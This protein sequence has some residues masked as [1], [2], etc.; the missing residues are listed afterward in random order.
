MPLSPAD[1]AKRA[2]A[3]AAIELV[4]DGM[5]L[6]LGSGSTAAFFVEL[7][8]ARLAETGWRVTCVPTS[9]GTR[10]LAEQLGVP[11]ST[12]DEAGPLDLAVDGADELDDNLDLIKGGGGALLL[13]KIVAH[14]SA[15][16]IVIADAAKHVD[17][18]GAFPL[19]V[20]IVRF[21]WQTTA[22]HVAE[23]LRA[24]DLGG[25]EVRLRERDGQ[26]FVTDEG[27]HILDL[28]LGRIGDAGVLEFDL[29]QIPGVVET[30]LF[31]GMADMAILGHEDGSTRTIERDA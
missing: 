30:G 1:R 9:S 4:R 12:L 2:A 22:R 25:H 14:A 13:E 15:R 17:T 29:G 23:A 5:K 10:A 27:H 20:E 11:L 19:P 26:P 3:A 8:A 24:N 18:L 16:F 31:L 28:H 7:L 21:G 6:G